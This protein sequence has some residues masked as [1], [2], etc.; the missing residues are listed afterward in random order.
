VASGLVDA[1]EALQLHIGS[2][3][4]P[5]PEVFRFLA[6]TYAIVSPTLVDAA[7]V[8]ST[9]AAEAG[10]PLISALWHVMSCMFTKEQY[11]RLIKHTQAATRKALGRCFV[12]FVFFCFVSV[13][14]RML[15]CSC[16]HVLRVYLH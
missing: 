16:V 11:V 4:P 2:T 5:C 8:N 3:V 7:A 1:A 13:H 9:A 10:I 12:C 15:P 14:F 6:R